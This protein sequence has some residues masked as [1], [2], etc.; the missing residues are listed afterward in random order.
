[1]AEI[2]T[3]LTP[4]LTTASDLAVLV[5]LGLLVMVVKE[6]RGTQKEVGE[7]KVA[8]FNGIKDRQQQLEQRVTR[9]ENKRMDAA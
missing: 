9:L 7:I 3:V 6:L 4:F 2:L 8:L 5:I 1:M